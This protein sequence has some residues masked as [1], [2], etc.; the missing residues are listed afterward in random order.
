MSSPLRWGVLGL[1]RAGRA[2]AR[3][4]RADPRAELVAGLRGD[5]AAVDLPEWP[6]ARILAHCDAVAV[7]SPSPLHPRHVEAALRADCH[8]VCEFPLAASAGQARALMA[9]A[10]ER[11]RV[12]HT[13]HIELLGGV[14]R[15][16]GAQA[17]QPTSGLLRFQSGPCQGSV[18]HANIARLHR[19][20]HALGWPEGHRVELRTASQFIG[21]LR[22]PWGELGLNFQHAEGLKRGTHMVLAG[23]QT[24]VQ[25]DGR[26]CLDGEAVALPAGQGLFLQDQLAASARILDDAPPYVSDARILGVLE[27]AHALDQ[28]ACPSV[29]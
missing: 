23:A 8:V 12:L 5:P 9:L 16:L 17:L 4:I 7:C 10:S 19:A 1:G 11:G 26:L 18:I 22:Y 13:E 24:W 25:Q 21:A 29:E 28:A 20:V 6:Q 3:A 14:S 15:V 27:L 2:R